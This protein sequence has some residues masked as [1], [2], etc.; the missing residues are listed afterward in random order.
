MKSWGEIRV[1]QRT[2]TGQDESGR[3]TIFV[4]RNVEGND[5][6]VAVG[7]E[8]YLQDC[9]AEIIGK[10]TIIHPFLLW[11]SW[12]ENFSDFCRLTKEKL[13]ASG[14]FTENK[15]GILFSK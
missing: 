3:T 6:D 4:A 11:G 2:A 7:T 8:K 13:L 15:Y 12:E 14:E 1:T 10:V 9:G 5:G